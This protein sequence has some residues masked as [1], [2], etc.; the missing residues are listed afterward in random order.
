MDGTRTA[1]LLRARQEALTAEL[2]VQKIM[3]R[4]VKPKFSELGSN[5]HYH[6]QRVVSYQLDDL[7]RR[8][9]SL[10]FYINYIILKNKN[11]YKIPP[12]GFEPILEATVS[13]VGLQGRNL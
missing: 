7:R 5:Q 12:I 13:S 8:D 11:Q 2:K 4:F 3:L 9:V 1:D 6:L 10:T